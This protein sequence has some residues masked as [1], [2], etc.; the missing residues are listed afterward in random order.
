[1]NRIYFDNS[2]TTSV[3]P[4]VREIV[5]RTMTED[6]GNPSSMHMAGVEA[7]NYVKEAKR[8]IAKTLRAKEKEIFFTS[9]GTES[10]NWA[11]IGTAAAMRRAGTHIVTSAE[12]HPS[13]SETLKYL[14]EQGFSVTR[15][16]VDQYGMLKID[17]FEQALTP[18]TILVSVMYVNNEVG[19]VND[20]AKLNAII[21]E[22]CPRAV[23]HVDAVQA[24]G[25][26][27]IPVRKCGIDL[28][29]VSGH[30]IHGPKGTGFLYKSENVRI[31]PII[32]GGGQQDGLRSGTDNVP[33]IAGLGKAAELSYAHLEENREKLYELK[34]YARE[35][36]AELDKVV[37]H[38]LPGE[39]SA[40]HIVNASFLGVGSEVLL[41]ALEDYGICVSAGSAC[42]THKRTKSP[43]L[44][45]MGAPAEELDSMI[46]LSFCE[47]NTKEEIDVMITAL[48]KLLPMLRR[49]R[50]H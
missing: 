50:A 26:Y 41:H 5:C 10:N 37:L 20:P 7:E 49:Y 31:L 32:R 19:A 11:L 1:M 4:E 27:E 22:K 24:Y 25:K 16:G 14:E 30:K 2:A 38:G 46:R 8:V 48:G 33:G 3:Y 36:L 43:T 15:V 28:L 39:E 42:S 45:A 40:P 47:T 29:S 13:V 23:F 12:E 44:T 18:D 34:A 17:E 35:R 9:G 6:F 21:R